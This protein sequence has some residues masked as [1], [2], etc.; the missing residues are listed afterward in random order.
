L[1]G[2]DVKRALEEIKMKKMMWI[3]SMGVLLTVLSVSS[4]SQ[5]SG[6]AAF[7]TYP[8]DYN[9]AYC[10]EVG[11]SK[12]L[13]IRDLFG[14]DTPFLTMY[15]GKTPTVVTLESAKGTDKEFTAQLLLT[16]DVPGKGVIKVVRLLVKFDADS[17]AEKSYV[18]YLKFVNLSNGQAT[19]DQSSGD[20]YSKGKIFGTFV[21]YMAMFWDEAALKQR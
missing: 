10:N 19:E 13:T 11:Y 9:I 7:G 8:A 16:W 4:C 21:G 6:K 20:E 12:G 15:K 14:Q 3:G 18:S 5:E 1:S 17:M 2:E